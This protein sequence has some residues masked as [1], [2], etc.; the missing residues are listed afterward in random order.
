MDFSNKFNYSD[1]LY[2]RRGKFFFP[3]SIK[4]K[5]DSL[6][7]KKDISFSRKFSMESLLD[8]VKKFQINLIDN[9]HQKLNIINTKVLLSLFKDCLSNEL[10]KK[11]KIYDKIH[12]QNDKKKRS[13]RHMIKTNNGNLNNS[14]NYKK[15]AEQLKYINFNIE[16]EIKK[17]DF[18]IKEKKALKNIEYLE[19]VE[20]QR[21]Y[22]DLNDKNILETMK[23]MEN[24]KK[25]LN[26]EFIILSKEKEKSDSEIKDINNIKLILENK[27]N[28]RER[29]NINLDLFIK[30]CDVLCLSKTNSNSYSSNKDTNDSSIKNINNNISNFKDINH[31]NFD[32]L[33]KEIVFDLDIHKTLKSFHSSIDTEF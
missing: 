22:C 21:I 18:M 9:N 2:L 23:I 10:N 29:T 8:T 30:K 27:I 20:E 28:E 19:N 12:K 31:N 16:N 11:R 15:E 14:I 13:I 1:R 25:E 4:I 26:Q 6:N 5:S 3:E 24:E 7:K 32:Y 33:N 17:I